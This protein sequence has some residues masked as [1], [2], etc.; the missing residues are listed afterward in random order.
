MSIYDLIK[1]DDLY[2]SDSDQKYVV[3]SEEEILKILEIL[4]SDPNTPNNKEVAEKAIRWAE[5]VRTDHLLLQGIL[6][7]RVL[8]K[9]EHVDDE[10]LFASNNEET[11]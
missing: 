7:G 8:M 4:F 6:S 10:I 5:Q 3:L 9:I 1:K 2:W 11:V